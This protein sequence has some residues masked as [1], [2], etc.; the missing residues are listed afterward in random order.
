MGT[1][2][3]CHTS[4][5][6]IRHAMRLLQRSTSTRAYALAMQRRFPGLSKWRI[7]RARKDALLLLAIQ[8]ESETSGYDD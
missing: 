2:R 5:D 4:E 1:K 7:D 6:I 3:T 8:K